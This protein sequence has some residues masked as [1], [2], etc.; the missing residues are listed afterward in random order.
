MN[1]PVLHNISMA[2]LPRMARGGFINGGE[3]SLTSNQYIQQLNIKLSEVFAPVSSLSG[4]NQQKTVLARWLAVK[5][6]ILILDEPT[7]GIDVGAKAEIYDLMRNLADTG[8]CILLI[9]SELP[10]VMAM[11]D[12]IV[13]MH[14]GRLAGILDHA[15]ATE[16]QIMALA[17]SR[18]MA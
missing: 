4:G 15:D 5:P 3:E 17:T 11:A 13:V 2:Q 18:A 9:S 10:E 1:L 14:E 7:H 12:R 6:R 16:N 8:I